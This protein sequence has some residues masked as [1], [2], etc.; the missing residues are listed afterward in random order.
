V[1]KVAFILLFLPCFV[2]S[3]DGTFYINGQA[4]KKISLSLALSAIDFGD[5]Y[6]DSEVASVGA[7]FSVNAEN[8]YDYRVE[9]SNDD[10]TGV[11]QVARAANGGFTADSITYIETA[12]GVDQAHKFYVDLSTSNLSG[13]LSAKITVMV[14]YNDIAE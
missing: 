5:V 1:S 9:I 14:A 10:S 8:G 7:D 3:A 6:R 11:V 13:D 2:G 12:T 4:V